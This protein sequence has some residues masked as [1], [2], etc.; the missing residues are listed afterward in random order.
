MEISRRIFL[1][2]GILAAAACAAA[3]L[4]ALNQ[5]PLPE[6]DG[7]ISPNHDRSRVSGSRPDQYA[8]LERLDRESFV[9]AIGSAFKVQTSAGPVWLRLLA[10]NDLS[11]AP[12]P[13]PGTFAVLNKKIS[14]TSAVETSGFM[15]VFSGT[16]P[17]SAPQ[18]TYSFAHATLGEF[19]LFIVPEGSNPGVYNAVINRLSTSSAVSPAVAEGTVELHAASPGQTARV[20]AAPI[21]SGNGSLSLQ[22]AETRGAQRAAARD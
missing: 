4:K 11:G 13:N 15:L 8:V 12:A 9:A 2:K 7:K 18:G 6:A 3:P 1:Q 14:K 22:R 5:S 20:P 17:D 19:A 10:V 21:S 16:S